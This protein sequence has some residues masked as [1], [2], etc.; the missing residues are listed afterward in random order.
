[1]VKK[2]DKTVLE[3][4][5]EFE[6][7]RLKQ[8]VWCRRIDSDELA[9]GP[10]MSIHLEGAE[11]CFTLID[12]FVGSYRMA[13]F[14]SIIPIPNQ[15]MWHQLEKAHARDEKKMARLL[16]KREKKFAARNPNA[17]KMR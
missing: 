16:D 14:S 5:Q 8:E 4:T 12:T 13:L 7:W 2:T 1:M 15:A 10:I 11:P 3:P 9:F 6:G 17:G